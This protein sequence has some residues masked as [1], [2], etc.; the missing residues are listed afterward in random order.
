MKRSSAVVWLAA[1]VGCTNPYPLPALPPSHPASLEAAEA[2]PAP[3]D[4]G[5]APAHD[6]H[7]EHR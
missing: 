1:L 7:G 3:A 5:A 2:S 4:R 6:A